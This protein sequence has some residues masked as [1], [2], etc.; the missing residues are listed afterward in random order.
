[1]AQRRSRTHSELPQS[2]AKKSVCEQVRKLHAP[3]MT[4]TAQR[5]KR[6][7]VKAIN[8]LI[9]H[10][11]KLKQTQRWPPEFSMVRAMTFQLTRAPTPLLKPWL[12]LTPVVH[13]ST[14]KQIIPGVSPASQ[15]LGSPRCRLSATVQ[16]ESAS[17]HLRTT[18][19]LTGCHV[20]LLPCSNEEIRR[21]GFIVETESPEPTN[22]VSY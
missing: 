14:H 20:A 17:H 21:R 8:A 5:P 9:P 6:D 11:R 10:H 16:C 4:A 22:D 7:S 15:V 18:V 3:C 1:M 2:E 13:N 12:S 19:V